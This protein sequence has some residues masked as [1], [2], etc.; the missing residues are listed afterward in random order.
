M[1]TRNNIRKSK[2]NIF[3]NFFNSIMEQLKRRDMNTMKTEFIN[4]LN[5]QQHQLSAAIVELEKAKMLKET[6]KVQNLEIKVYSINKKILKDCEIFEAFFS[7]H[8]RWD[9]N[10]D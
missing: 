3:S 4:D 7:Y 9:L 8:P 5:E 2:S 10:I 1:Y 6:N